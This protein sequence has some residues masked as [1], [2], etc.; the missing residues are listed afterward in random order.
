MSSFRSKLDYFGMAG[1]LLCAIHCAAVP[2]I[3]TVGS[4]GSF[5]WLASHGFDFF[6]L[7][8]GIVFA[9]ASLYHSYVKHHR[10]NRPMLLAGVGFVLLSLAFTLLH[11]IEAVLAVIG[12]LLVFSAHFWNIRLNKKSKAAAACDSCAH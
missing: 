6:F 10:N 12:G 1:S 3:L 11:D 4:L 2:I 7:G 9:V 5:S 8:L